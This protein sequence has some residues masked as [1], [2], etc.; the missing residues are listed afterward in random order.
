MAR[1][2]Q[3]P[4]IQ[5]KLPPCGLFSMQ[6]IPVAVLLRCRFLLQS[7]AEWHALKETA[8]RRRRS[9]CYVLVF[10]LSAL[11]VGFVAVPV[12]ADAPAQ[13]SHWWCCCGLCYAQLLYLLLL[14]LLLLL[15]M[16]QLFLQ[17]GCLSSSLACLLCRCSCS[18]SLACCCA[19]SHS[20]PAQTTK[21]KQARRVPKTRKRRARSAVQR[22]NESAA[23]IGES[24]RAERGPAPSRA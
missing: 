10:T 13:C 11:F 4:S 21:N 1:P 12:A 7:G 6:E 16:E 5:R 19:S 9:P 18:A 15:L 2:P 20:K 3:L 17:G 22:K 8:R 24:V 14:L 23:G